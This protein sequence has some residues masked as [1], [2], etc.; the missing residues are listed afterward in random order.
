MGPTLAVPKLGRATTEPL[1]FSIIKDGI[2]GTEMPRSRLAG[3]EIRQMATHRCTRQ[4]DPANRRQAT[5]GFLAV[6]AVVT[7]FFFA[8]ESIHQIPKSLTLK[9]A[10]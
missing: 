5:G 3:E 7:L 8:V 2:P 9:E 1:L 10:I 6:R 4:L